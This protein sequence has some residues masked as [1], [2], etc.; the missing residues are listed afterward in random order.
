MRQ[1]LIP[2][3]GRDQA[4]DDRDQHQYSYPDRIVGNRRSDFGIPFPKDQAK[5]DL[6]AGGSERCVWGRAIRSQHKIGQLSFLNLLGVEK[7]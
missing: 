7:R 1:I 6:R 4:G 2:E 3:P 5:S